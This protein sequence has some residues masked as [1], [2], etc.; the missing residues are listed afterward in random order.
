MDIFVVIVSDERISIPGIC[1][2]VA[3]YMSIEEEKIEGRGESWG[4]QN[5]N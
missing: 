5:A 4:N 2:Y 3:W 1:M